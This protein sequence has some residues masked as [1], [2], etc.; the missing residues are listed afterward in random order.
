VREA[1][2]GFTVSEGVSEGGILDGGTEVWLQE[3]LSVHILIHEQ[4][5]RWEWWETF[6]FSKLTPVN[7]HPQQGHTS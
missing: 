7:Y 6:E 3:E 4:E 2:I 5:T 1:L